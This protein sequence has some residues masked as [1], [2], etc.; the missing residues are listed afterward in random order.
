VLTA[1]DDRAENPQAS[2]V[3]SYGFWRRRFGLDQAIVG[4]NIRLKDVPFTIVGVAPPGFSGFEV[5]RSPDLWW[6]LQMTPRLYPGS[7]ILNARSSWWLRLMGRLRPGKSEAQARAELDL[8]F[9]PAL[10]EIL[11]SFGAKRTPA[12]RRNFLERKIE[13]QPGRAGWTTLRKQL[14]Q[15][16]LILMT[17]VALALAVACAN[18]ANLL[19]ARAAGRVPEI[20]MRLALGA[21]RMRLV[22]QLLTESALLALIGGALGLLF[23]EWGAGLLLAYLPSHGDLSFNVA[24]DSRVLGFTL[25]ISML[26]GLLF[27]LAPALRAARF[28]IVSMLKDRS[29]GSGKVW[30]RL[31]LNKAL[32][33]TQV[34]RNRWL[35]IIAILL[36]LGVLELLLRPL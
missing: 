33:A 7:R 12:E 1:E 13:L 25:A 17:M 18:V 8:I 10:A 2:V 26:T 34:A 11:E 23:A 9:R 24:P 29:I 32:V 20:A 30:S 19:L 5:G 22:R 31:S 6:P 21:G 28:D 4:K 15:P 3:I 14:K 27:G 35:A 36:V 16:L